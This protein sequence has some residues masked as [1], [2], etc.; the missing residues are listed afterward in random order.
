MLDPEEAKEIENDI[1]KVQNDL[2]DLKAA[3]DNIYGL[4]IELSN[5]SDSDI[6]KHQKDL[7]QSLDELNNLKN[8]DLKER[9]KDIDAI[10]EKMRNMIRNKRFKIRKQC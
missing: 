4:L 7:K 8:N 2:D 3:K 9:K 1:I 5:M 6:I 10:K